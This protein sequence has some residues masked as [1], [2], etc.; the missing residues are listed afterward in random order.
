MATKREQITFSKRVNK[1]A[2][3]NNWETLE[4]ELRK[5][6]KKFS[7]EYWLMTTLANCL[8]EQKKY[9]EALKYSK[10]ALMISPDDPLVIYD[11]AP[12]L[13]MN[14]KIKEAIDNWK[15]IEKM[16]L[17]QIAFGEFGEGIRWA[18]SI[19]NNVYYHLA[20]TYKEK[21]NVKE[22]KRYLQKN[23]KNR[24][25]GLFCIVTKKMR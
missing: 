6:L 21:K 20:I 25:R 5:E 18:K 4:K 3:E 12:I 23:L 24:N 7:D 19:K 11:Y 17:N 16:G 1:L 22:F 10:K 15:K 13:K 8:Y 2:Q 14:G 9:S